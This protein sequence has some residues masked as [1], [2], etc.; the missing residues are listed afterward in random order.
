MVSSGCDLRWATQRLY[1]NGLQVASRSQTG[2]MQASGGVLR[3]GGNN[4]WNEYF[5][6]RIDEVRRTYNRA[7]TASQ[8]Q[9]DM[10]EAIEATVSG[11]LAV[12]NPQM[13]PQLSNMLSA[14]GNSTS[15]L[16]SASQQTANGSSTSSTSTTVTTPAGLLTSDHVEIGELEVNDQWKRVDLSKPFSDPIVVAKAL[17]DRD[18]APVV[19]VIRQADATGFQLRL[20][21][22][23]ERSRSPAF[24]MVGYLAIERG[25]FRLPD[26]SSLESGTVDA[27][28][29]Y[30]EHSI[31]FSQPFRIA[32]VVMTAVPTVQDSMVATGRPALVSQKGFQFR[33]QPQGFSHS[34]DAVQTISYVACE[35]SKGTLGNLVFEVNKTRIVTRGQSQTIPYTE[36]FTH[37]PVFLADLQS[38][39]GGNP[40]NVRWEQ[41]D[42]QGTDVKID[43]ISDFETNG[44]TP[45][46]TDVVGYLLIR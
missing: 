33:L 24:E 11:V 8:I 45:E 43:D 35:P 46:D 2:Q 1:V 10:N 5:Q 38:S 39:I 37:P 9:A 12:Q 30:P 7:L 18:A 6:G 13:S 27:N 23:G 42:P 15:P 32:P 31:A 29:A 40:I 4:I 36:T 25:R 34:V 17:S 3:I 26:G 20:Q 19:V 44:G 22:W 16:G 21:P 14:L 41:K 28:P